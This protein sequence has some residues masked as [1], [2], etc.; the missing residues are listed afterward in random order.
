MIGRKKELRIRVNET[1]G[2][3]KRDHP[4]QWKQNLKRNSGVRK[5]KRKKE[6]RKRNSGKKKDEK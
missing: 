6:K 1:I 5:R 4:I 2:Q 3:R